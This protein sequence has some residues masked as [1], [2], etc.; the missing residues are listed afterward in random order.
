MKESAKPRTGERS[1]KEKSATKQSTQGKD[2]HVLTVTL[3]SS[4]YYATDFSVAL[5][6][7]VGVERYRW[8]NDEY[9]IKFK[10]LA[11]LVSASNE[12]GADDKY[13]IDG[14]PASFERVKMI[15]ENMITKNAIEDLPEN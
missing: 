12:F 14:K 10:S 1:A 7:I 13:K 8:G 4:R 6:D 11:G 9:C 3:E 2:F 15:L 5:E